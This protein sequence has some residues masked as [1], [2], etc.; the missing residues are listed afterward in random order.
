MVRCVGVCGWVPFLSPR[1]LLAGSR[2]GGLGFGFESEGDVRCGWVGGWVVAWA[3]FSTRD[4]PVYVGVFVRFSTLLSLPC[5]FR[6]ISRVC[7]CVCV[8]GVRVEVSPS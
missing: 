6:A 8:C 5:L 3:R 2:L 7:A 1:S 4:I